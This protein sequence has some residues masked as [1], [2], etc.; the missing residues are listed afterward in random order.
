MKLRDVASAMIDGARV[1]ALLRSGP[2]GAISGRRRAFAG[3][4][5]INPLVGAMLLSVGIILTALLSL[6]RLTN[7]LGTVP[8]MDTTQSAKPW[9]ANCGWQSDRQLRVH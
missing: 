6:D 8:W 2:S 1:D 5:Q 3:A 7:G 4:V 9:L